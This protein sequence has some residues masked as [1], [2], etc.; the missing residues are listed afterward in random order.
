M[1]PT[2]FAIVFPLLAAGIGAAVVA[3]Q[4]ASSP[5][6]LVDELLAADRAFA[7]GA[8]NH[9]VIDALAPM[10]ASDVVMPVP[11]GAFA[12]GKDKVVEAL[13]GNP[14]NVQGKAEWFP[15]RGGISADGQHGF[16][17]G[18]MTVTRG[19]GT[20]IPVK[21]LSYW[22]K[23][24][25][26]WRVAIYK[27]AR[28]AEG[29]IPRDA[30][31]PAL[32]ATLVPPSSDPAAREKHRVSLEQAEKAFSDEAQKIGIGPAFAK[33]GSADAVNMGGPNTATFIVGADAIGKNV[34]AGG[35]V[36]ESP[37]NWAAD[38]AVLVASSGDLGATMG[39]IKRN[40]PVPAG[41]PAA[42]PFVTIWRRASPAD[43]WRYVA[44]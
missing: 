11:T 37:V 4:G 25:D 7:S 34:G 10:F 3:A 35:P 9:T 23:Q 19:D 38:Y 32:P 8:A 40:G 44:E 2:R 24:S 5:K 14:D 39:M 1:R 36:N 20:R 43:P 33:N 30:L 29:T 21:Y 31:A 16:T 27:R 41:Q 17:V 28:S 15:A 6:A 12:R 13:K 42:V 26:G 22:V 18:Y